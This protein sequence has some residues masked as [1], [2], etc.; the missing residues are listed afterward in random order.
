[1]TTPKKGFKV[2]K[3]FLR[4]SCFIPSRLSVIYPRGKWVRP[5]EDCGPLAVFTA[6]IAADSFAR[7]GLRAVPCE[8]HPSR[9]KRMW[10]FTSMSLSLNDAPRDTVLASSVKCLE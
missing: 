5:A 8:Y 1:M 9:H 2:L 6:Q 10:L 3:P 4:S 7:Q